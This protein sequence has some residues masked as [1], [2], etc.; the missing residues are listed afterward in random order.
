[1][2][3]LLV[4]Q[5]VSQGSG[6]VR[7]N[8]KLTGQDK[9]CRNDKLFETGLSNSQRNIRSLEENRAISKLAYFLVLEILRRTPATGV[10]EGKLITR[11]VNDA[12]AFMKEG[13]KIIINMTIRSHQTGLLL[14]REGIFV[15]AIENNIGRKLLLVD[16]GEAGKEYVFDHEVEAQMAN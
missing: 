16:F 13:D 9:N 4:N 3:Q 5:T 8:L 6:G 1:M 10:L 15:G 7:I 11:L 14:P 2:V 12:G